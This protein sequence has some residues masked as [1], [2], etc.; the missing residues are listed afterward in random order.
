MTCTTII[1]VLKDKRYYYYEPN[2]YFNSY[3]EHSMNIVY[4]VNLNDYGIYSFR[5]S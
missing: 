1:K 4:D 2:V 3:T 5:I